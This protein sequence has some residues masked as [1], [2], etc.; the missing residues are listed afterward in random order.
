VPIPIQS[1]LD[2]TLSAIIEHTVDL[3]VAG[4]PLEFEVMTVKNLENG[5]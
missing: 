4:A 3:D 5:L 1:E 2:P